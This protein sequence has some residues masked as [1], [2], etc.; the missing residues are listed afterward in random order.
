MVKLVLPHVGISTYFRDFQKFVGKTYGIKIR[1]E[2]SFL[3]EGISFSLRQN[4]PIACFLIILNIDYHLFPQGNFR[5][6]YHE[7]IFIAPCKPV[8]KKQKYN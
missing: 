4:N 1:K 3:I 2:G 6:V 7:T 5:K 8:V